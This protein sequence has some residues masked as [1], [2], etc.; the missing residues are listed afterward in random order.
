MAVKTRAQ[1]LAGIQ[2]TDPADQERNLIESVPVGAQQSNI[3]EIAITYTTGDPEIVPDGAVTIANGATPSAS[4]LLELCEEIIAKQNSIVA[5]L[6]AFG[7][8]ADS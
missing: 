6:E 7:I 2:K 8:T 5:A 3:A 1:L 4:E